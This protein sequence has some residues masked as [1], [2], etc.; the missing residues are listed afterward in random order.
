MLRPQP[1]RPGP[2]T[3]APASTGIQDKAVSGSIAPDHRPGLSQALN[4]LE[5]PTDPAQTLIA[6][7]LSLDPDTRDTREILTLA[8]RAHSGGWKLALLREA[9]Q[10]TA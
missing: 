7:N 4:R 2:P 8:D 9:Y 10:L 1:S 3:Q 5:D 6:T